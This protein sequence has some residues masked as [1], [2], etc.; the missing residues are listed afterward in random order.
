MTIKY[1]TVYIATDGRQ[2]LDLEEATH[3]EKSLETPQE[4]ST[5]KNTSNLTDSNELEVVGGPV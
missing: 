5:Y 1:M 4:E 2:F 3:Y